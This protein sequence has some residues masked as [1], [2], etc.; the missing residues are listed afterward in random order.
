MQGA[1]IKIGNFID[2][3]QANT[4]TGTVLLNGSKF[5]LSFLLVFKTHLTMTAYK[6]L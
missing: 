5:C 6:M 2:F 1:K 3:F 4:G